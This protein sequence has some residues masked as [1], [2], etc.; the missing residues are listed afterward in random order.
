MLPNWLNIRKETGR[1]VLVAG[2]VVLVGLGGF[3]LGRFSVQ[4]APAGQGGLRVLSREEAAAAGL[5]GATEAS[6]PTGAIEGGVVASKSGTKYHYPWCAGA[7]SIKEEN[8]VWFTSTVEA[9]AA[10]YL[11][12][13]NCKGLE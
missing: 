5:V 12:A 8:K 1:D 10:G 9:R 6:A 4:V 13:S 11:P 2:V 3:F 7:Q